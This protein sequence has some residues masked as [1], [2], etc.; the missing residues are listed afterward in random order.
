MPKF[1]AIFALVV[2][3]L[4]A[5][6]STLAYACMCFYSGAFQEYAAS[7]PIVIRGKVNLGD[8]LPRI[9]SNTYGF[10][11]VEVQEVLKGEF[12]H[13]SILFRGGDG[14]SCA[15]YMS[16]ADYPNGSEH[17]FIL[18]STNE[19]QDLLGCGEVSVRITGDTVEG[20]R[21]AGGRY[22]PYQM[23]LDALTTLINSVQK[24]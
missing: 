23:S 1:S 8:L 16:S 17:L 19:R 12:S 5:S 24:K 21:L 13:K 20:Q 22:Q 9:S 4:I 3:L 14:M 2:T 7:N 10:M 18:R 6:L 15:K 11:R